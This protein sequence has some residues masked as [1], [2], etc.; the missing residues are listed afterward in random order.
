MWK[1][2]LQKQS[3]SDFA[4]AQDDLDL[5]LSQRP[6]GGYWCD[7]VYTVILIKVFIWQDHDLDLQTRL[8]VISSE[9]KHDLQSSFSTLSNLQKHLTHQQKTTSENIVVRGEIAHKKQLL[10]LPEC[11]QLYSMIILSCWV[12][13]HIF[14]QSCLKKIFYH[15]YAELW[16]YIVYPVETID[17]Y[18][19]ISLLIMQLIMCNSL[20]SHCSF[21]SPYVTIIWLCFKEDRKHCG[22]RRTAYN[23]EFLFFPIF[24]LEILL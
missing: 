22:N 4:E 8:F 13:C 10:L 18:Q 16:K 14:M 3:W 23:E 21:I 1:D 17:L 15:E 7:V 2:F 24:Y 9:K 6:E 19:D 12:I 5:C 11:F 20:Y